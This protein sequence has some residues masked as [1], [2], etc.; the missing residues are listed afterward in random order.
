MWPFSFHLPDEI[1]SSFEAS[2]GFIRYS[3]RA[4]SH[5]QFGFDAKSLIHFSVNSPLDLNRSN[6]ALVS[7]NFIFSKIDLFS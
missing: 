6:E 2:K 1:P 4:K 7:G 5:V 3:L